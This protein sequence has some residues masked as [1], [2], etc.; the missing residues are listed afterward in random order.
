MKAVSA[1]NKQRKDC[2]AINKRE[3]FSPKI[4]E[5]K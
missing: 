5:A 4:V 3:K 1:Q 2:A